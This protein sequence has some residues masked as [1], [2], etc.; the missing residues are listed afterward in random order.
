M[1]LRE[2]DTILLRAKKWDN[3]GYCAAVGDAA[4]R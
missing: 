1:T 4:G 2:Q 3:A